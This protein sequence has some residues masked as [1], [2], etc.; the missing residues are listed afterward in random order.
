MFGSLSKISVFPF[1]TAAALLGMGAVH[2]SSNRDGFDSH[3]ADDASSPGE[4]V[5]PEA[6]SDADDSSVAPASQLDCSGEVKLIYV[7]TRSPKAIHRFDPEALTYTLLGN[8]QCPF[9][10]EPESMAVDRQGV[11]W[12]R[13]STGRM[14]KIPLDTFKC[15]EFAF[16]DAPP[17][18][19]GRGG[20]GF[21]A[22]D[23]G[24][25]ESL[26]AT[27]DGALYHIDPTSMAVTSAV[28]QPGVAELTGTG[29]G[30]LYAYFA[31]NGVLARLDKTTGAQLQTYRTSALGGA[32][33]VAQWGGDFYLFHS[34]GQEVYVSTVTRFSPATGESVEVIPNSGYDVIGAGSST[35][36][37]FKPVK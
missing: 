32:F 3:G 5:A 8:V 10:G 31:L 13:F 36:A 27:S 24:T 15:T 9:S 20:M 28:N 23:S 18:L 14:A 21:V 7:V 25:G 34:S 30:K 11:A 37:P 16:Q 1:A 4:F 2:C 33:A 22:D 17:A 6:G 26:Y 12:V 29:D 35:C 19:L